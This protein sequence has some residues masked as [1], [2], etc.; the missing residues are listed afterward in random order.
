MLPTLRLLLACAAA[1]LLG[2]SCAQAQ[3]SDIAATKAP[4]PTPN[5]K[6]PLRGIISMGAYKFVGGKPGTQPDNNLAAVRAKPGLLG[7]IVIVPSWQQLQP[8]QG[9]PLQTRVID[10]MLNQIRIYNSHHPDHPLAAKLRVWGGFVAPLWAK[11]LNNTKP[12]PVVQNDGQPNEQHRTLGHFWTPAYRQAWAQLQQMLAQQYDSEPLIRE[13][14]ITSCMSLTAEPFVVNT[15]P[16]VIRRLRRNGFTDQAFKDCLTGALDDYAVWKRTRLVLSVNPL[17][18]YHVPGPGDPEF[19]KGIMLACRNRFGAQ[20]VFDNHD[21]NVPLAKPLCTIY[22]Y[23]ASLGP[24]IEFQT[25]NIEPANFPGTMMF[26]VKSGA[27]SIELYQDF[28]NK[29]GFPKVPD[30]TLRQWSRWLAQNTGQSGPFKPRSCP[31]GN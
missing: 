19:T 23:M 27:S 2:M 9:G 26:G 20:C 8:V 5:L 6:P 15:Q 31:T 11:K 12:I 17:H 14:S 18:L 1:V 30:A 28:P 24:E 3:P 10:T 4:A 29:G 25:A 22:A 7:G 13:V 16:K 21:L